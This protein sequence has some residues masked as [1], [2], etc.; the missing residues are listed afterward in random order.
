M[1]D[2]R[3]ATGRPAHRPSHGAETLRL[4]RGQEPD[5][6]RTGEGRAVA[7]HLHRRCAAV[8][9]RP[10][11]ARGRQ[12][13]RVVGARRHRQGGQAR[14]RTAVERGLGQRSAPG[15]RD[16]D[17]RDGDGRR[18]RRGSSVRR[19]V[20]RRGVPGGAARQLRQLHARPGLAKPEPSGEGAGSPVAGRSVRR[21]PANRARE[22]G[23][24]SGQNEA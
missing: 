18:D 3:G 11:S 4:W 20:D 5:G 13:V 24:Q 19:D 23:T 2:R 14:R 15:P 1:D 9:H 17:D 8:I 10:P 16:E 12:S 7:A 21:A 6:R 22:G